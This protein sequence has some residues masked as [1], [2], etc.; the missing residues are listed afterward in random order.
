MRFDPERLPLMSP[1]SCIAYGQTPSGAIGESA[2]KLQAGKF[3][4]V[5]LNARSS[6][7]SDPTRG[8]LAKFCLL[9]DAA[10][11]RQLLPVKPGT[12]AWRDEVCD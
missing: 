7:S 9:V 8:Y 1:A 4:T 5:H 11:G 12:R 2:A 10:G 6:D 3:Y